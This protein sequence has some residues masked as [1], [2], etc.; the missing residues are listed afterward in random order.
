MNINETKNNQV[1]EPPLKKNKQT[2]KKQKKKTPWEGVC[3][4]GG[5]GGWGVGDLLNLPCTRGQL[6]M[7]QTC[8]VGSLNAKRYCLRKYTSFDYIKLHGVQF[9]PSGTVAGSEACLLHLQVDPRSTLSHILS[10]I[11]PSS[12]SSRKASC[13]LLAKQKSR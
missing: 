6:L 12:T 3:V 9:N 8:S 13:P 5:G 11:F 2:K 10:W 4:G 1:M 7:M